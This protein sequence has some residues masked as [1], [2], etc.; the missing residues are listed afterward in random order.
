MYKNLNALNAIKQLRQNLIDGNHLFDDELLNIIEEELKKREYKMKYKL[1]LQL[2]AENEPSETETI[3][4]IK[5]EYEKKLEEQKNSY[6]TK[7]SD[8][9][10]NHNEQIRALFSGRSENLSEETKK[11]QEKKE[12]S[13]EEQLLKDTR[14]EL[15]LKEE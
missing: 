14:K 13:F 2:F 4:I 10:K 1:N 7:I 15:G 5:E 6:E 11:L 12:L 8:L 3:K 9:N